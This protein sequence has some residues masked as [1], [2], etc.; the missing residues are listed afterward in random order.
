MR[1]KLITGGLVVLALAVVAIQ[2]NEWFVYPGLR[3][4]VSSH[5]KDPSSTQFKNEKLG[6][7]R[8]LCGEMNAKNSY[9]AFDGFKHFV[10]GPEKQV[11]IEGFGNM[12]AEKST[13]AV[14]EFLNAK[15]KAIEII[16]AANKVM[17][18]PVIR[19]EEQINEMAIK[20]LF[21]SQW[22]KVCT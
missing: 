13:E 16:N 9:G 15:I 20:E 19:T 18:D 22:D 14:L 17:K 1:L 5:M 7:T 12:S 3:A 8:W 11:Y 2:F 4:N 6:S 10:S 21:K